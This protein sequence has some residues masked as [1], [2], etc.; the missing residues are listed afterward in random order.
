MNQ[1]VLLK[2]VVGVLLLTGMLAVLS[3]STAYAAQCSLYPGS[4]WLYL[5]EHVNYSTSGRCLQFSDGGVQNL[6]KYNFNDALSSFR[7]KTGYPIYLYWN[8][9]GGY[10][11]LAVPAGAP[12]STMPSG[13]NDKVSSI[14]IKKP[15]VS[16][17]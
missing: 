17:P 2:T 5:Y 10:P 3:P 8:V 13:W 16:C 6:T 9:G 15:G 4:G 11:R 7:N 12:W 1:S 14:C